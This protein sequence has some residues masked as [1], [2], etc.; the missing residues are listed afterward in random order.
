MFYMKLQVPSGTR[1]YAQRFDMDGIFMNMHLIV[2]GNRQLEG[3]C[4]SP[5]GDATDDVKVANTSQYFTA[6]QFVP[7]PFYGPELPNSVASSWTYVRYHSLLKGTFDDVVSR[8]WKQH[9]V[10]FHFV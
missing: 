3:L 4:G 10:S 1:I 2:V 8:S 7:N 6:A 9:S 5:D